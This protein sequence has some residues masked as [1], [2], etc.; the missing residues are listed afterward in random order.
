[1][2]QPSVGCHYWLVTYREWVI[3]NP[4]VSQFPCQLSRRESG[5]LS[6]ICS[7]P[8]CFIFLNTEAMLYHELLMLCKR[9]W[10]LC[11]CVCLKCV[12][13]CEWVG[14]A[15]T[16]SSLPSLSTTTEF[17]K[18][19]ST[20]SYTLNILSWHMVS[21]A[22]TLLLCNILNQSLTIHEQRS[23][24][25]FSRHFNNKY[26][27]WNLTDFHVSWIIFF[28]FQWFKNVKIIVKLQAVQKQ[29][30]GWNQDMVCLCLK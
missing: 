30:V 11:I 29:V 26:I 2:D 23:F 20:L 17:T 16:L 18:N 19:V 4:C 22:T 3:W 21:I 1:M 15:V 28:V 8:Y 5:S 14:E 13:G 9:V 6:N 25:L 27:K 10:L 24:T 12:C 7:F